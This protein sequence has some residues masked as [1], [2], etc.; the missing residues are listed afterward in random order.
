MPT[1]SAGGYR[2]RLSRIP[3]CS[4]L[5]AVKAASTTVNVGVEAAVAAA[6]AV[7]YRVRI[8]FRLDGQIDR[9]VVDAIIADNVRAEMT[10]S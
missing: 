10:L 2:R 6:P 9:D 7:A 4:R 1:A 5:A 8:D 3:P